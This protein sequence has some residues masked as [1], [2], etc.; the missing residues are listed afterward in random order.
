MMSRIP[1]PYV[2]CGIAVSAASLAVLLRWLLLPLIGTNT[3]YLFLYPTVMFISLRLGMAS[4]ILT[5]LTGIVA[6]EIWVLPPV[7][8]PTAMVSFAVRGTMVLG[9]A[10]FIGYATRRIN[11]AKEL[12]QT[13]ALA[14][15]E[16][17]ERFRTFADFTYN[18]EYWL[19]PN[20]S[21]IYMS[22][23]CEY[24]T[25][26]SP[27]DFIANA[28]LLDGLILPEERPQW[29]RHVRGS[30]L[31]RESLNHEFRIRH[32]DGR[33]RWIGHTCRPVCDSAGNFRGWRVSNRDI[34][35]QK[36]AELE[37]QKSE[38]HYRSLFENMLAG[39]AHCRLLVDGGGRPEDFVYLRVNGAFS[40]ITGLENVT[41][42]KSGEVFPDVRA[43]N[44]ELFASYARVALGGGAERF[45]TEIPLLG[46]WLSVSVYSTEKGYFT[47]VFDNIT[48]RK[49]YEAT[50]READRRKDEYLGM[51]AHELRNPLAPIRNAA[52][53]LRAVHSGDS[54]LRR[55]RDII[56]RQVT[57]MARLLDDLLDVSRITRNKIFLHL[58]PVEIAEVLN[59]AREAAEPLLFAQRQTLRLSPPTPGLRVEGD[60]DRLVQVVG[61]LLTN[62]AKYTG[63][64]GRIWLQ[65]EAE[66]GNA[67][68]RVRDTGIGLSPEALGSIFDMFY[69]VNQTLDRSQGGLGIGL[70]LV[71]RLVEMHG[72][73]VEA[74]S[75]GLG[76]GCEFVVR[77]P[78]LASARPRA[79]SHPAAGIPGD[80]NSQTSSRE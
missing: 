22:P 59:R 58:R 29:N 21:L 46:V 16:S 53:L 2:R 18:W 47:A 51:L 77:L 66:D 13:H 45:E 41:G 9:V 17:E 34:T 44:P 1:I 8:L 39:F 31:R 79:S 42:K 48:E 38:N 37:L 56:D 28:A 43:S 11:T 50:L 63:E 30:R 80:R 23:S 20:R 14:L 76:Q 33:T 75:P 62:A 57:H 12:A 64:G 72:G 7:G 54:G 5:A 65:A 35:E 10:V 55:Q 6:T 71:R 73:T 4:G 3:L 36:L 70:T 24:V 49:R 74:H 68:I 52:Y 27:Q 15:R 19:A 32:R 60:F 40:R 78:A 26:Y 67:V 25:G 61:N 69:Q